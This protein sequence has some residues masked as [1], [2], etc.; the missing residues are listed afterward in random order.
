MGIGEVGGEGA[1]EWDKDEVKYQEGCQEADDT[2]KDIAMIRDS[3]VYPEG[4]GRDGGD[5]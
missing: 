5:G 2:G 4:S 3:C 1:R